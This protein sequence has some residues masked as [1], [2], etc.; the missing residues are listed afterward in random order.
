[1]KLS[2][3][4]KHLFSRGKTR[5]LIFE[6]NILFFSSA[7]KTPKAVIHK[8]LGVSILM[9]PQ[10]LFF[11]FTS[12]SITNYSS[13]PISFLP[14]SQMQTMY[15][16][17][18]ILLFMCYTYTTGKVLCLSAFFIFIFIFIYFFLPATHYTVTLE[19]RR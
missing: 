7:S 8:V 2:L 19:I 10:N 15:L 12:C 17:V 6:L 4:T 11:I 13:Q 1:M 14:H 3:R 5:C 9:L 18:R 16:W